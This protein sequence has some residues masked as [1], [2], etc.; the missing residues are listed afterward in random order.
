MTGKSKCSGCTC[1]K[2]K[3]NNIL[4]CSKECQAGHW[5]QHKKD[6]KGFKA[7]RELISGC[8]DDTVSG[9]KIV[10]NNLNNGVLL[11][12]NS[13]NAAVRI[14]GF[15]EC[16]VMLVKKDVAFF[17]SRV[18]SGGKV[19]FTQH[20]LSGIFPGY[21]SEKA[22]KQYYSMNV[23]RFL[24]FLNTPGSW[25]AVLDAVTVNLRVSLE[26][27][28]VRVFAR[29]ILRNMSDACACK[30]IADYILTH[31]LKV[32]AI[33]MRGL[34]LCIKGQDDRGRDPHSAIE[35]LVN[36]QISMLE[37]WGGIL[38]KDVDTD[39]VKFIDR[40]GITKGKEAQLYRYARQFAM[41]QIKEINYDLK[42]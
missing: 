2:D 30:P 40:V 18:R 16:L 15:L 29:D 32:T 37:Y 27:A 8:S 12:D 23:S 3:S 35:G 42:F 31:H 13:F 17:E 5:G 26:D 4:Y 39:G 36:Q 1:S 11:K 6:C 22:D 7:A 21:Q 14:P 20:M 34:W 41:Q 25:E 24:M 38:K 28:S 19:S 10:V 9:I 33:R